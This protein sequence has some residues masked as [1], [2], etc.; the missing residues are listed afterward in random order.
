M[1]SARRF[2]TAAIAAVAALAPADLARPQ[3][4]EPVPIPY[5]GI[6]DEFWSPK[7]RVFREVTIPDCFAKFEKDGAF[8]NFDR[9]RDGASGEHAGP[10]WYDGLVY[11]M[12]RASA[13]FL[14]SRRDPALEARIDGYVE[15]IGA[16]A[17]RDPDGYVNTWTQLEQPTRRWGLNGGDDNWQHDVYNAGALVDAAVHYYRAT[18]KTALLRIATRLAN[19]MCDV[20]GPPPKKNVVPGHA[21]AEEAFVKLCILFREKPELKD[22]MPVPIDEERYLRLAEFWIE[23]RGHHEGRKSFGPYGQDHLP[24]LEQE[25]IEGHA[26]R[27]TLLLAGLAAAAR[28]NGRGD[29]AR[30]AERLWENMVSRRMHVTGGV[31]AFADGERFGPD[32][33]LPNDAYLETCAAVGAAFFHHNLNLLSGDARC[34]DELERALYNGVLSGVSLEGDSYFYTNPLEA[35]RDRTRWS[36]HSCPCCP[37]MFLKIAGALP[38][39]IYA[40][41]SHG[42]FVNLFISS[43]A[44]CPAGG[45][46]V[47][48]RQTTSYP[49]D[50]VVRLRVD[51]KSPADFD[52]RLRIPGWCERFALKVNGD[53]VEDPRTISGYVR[54]YRQWTP[55]DEVELTLE[56]P[57]RRSKAHPKVASNLGRVAL[58]RGPLVYCVE[59][60]DSSSRPASL[61]LT[62]EAPLS[63]ERRP[64]LFGGATVIRASAKA[65]RRVDW[66][67]SLYLPAERAASLVDAEFVAIPYYANAN[68]GPD[69]M[70]VWLAEDPSRATPLPPPTLAS[71]STPSASHGNPGDTVDALNDQI[72]PDRSADESIPRFTWWDHRGT[73]EWVQ[74]DFGKR[75]SVS[76]VE[77]YWW[78]ER[79]IGRHCRVPASWRVLYRSGTE[80]EPV[81]GASRYGA[82]ID[83]WNEVRF[84]PVETTGLRLEVQLQPGWSGGI[85]EWKVVEGGTPSTAPSGARERVPPSLLPAPGARR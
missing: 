25:T 65:A 59:G 9:V 63:I 15:R 62:P 74:Y 81:R 44:W 64:D 28:W 70:R 57:V 40:R 33:Q 41:S 77:V 51:P 6:E 52:V 45:T 43:R 13:D 50:G 39:Y 34:A 69:E 42:I 18:A 49:W 27:A 11:E 29:Y 53:P 19:H 71:R 61:V 76:A 54:I 47:A 85:L 22:E 37:P 16:A 24:V 32:Y 36:W 26:V 68:R 80:W 10:P 8:A 31:G 67:R 56:M 4:L 72:E 2:L 38:G 14:A 35:G 82:E 5:V 7:L 79:R 58:L 60:Q 1:R 55:G 83:R 12:V 48:L 73:A 46:L 23:N 20:M 66:G 75:A 30:A 21:L 78:D 3:G 84:E 17:A